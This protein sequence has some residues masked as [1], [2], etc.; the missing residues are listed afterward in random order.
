MGRKLTDGQ[1]REKISI[2]C[3]CEKCEKKK[4]C[5]FKGQFIRLPGELFKG[6]MGKC[7]KIRNL[8]F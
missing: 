1:L 6:G 3:Y 7:P 8:R 2:I 5:E 4:E